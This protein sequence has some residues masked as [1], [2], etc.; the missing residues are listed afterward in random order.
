MS[1]ATFWASKCLLA[2]VH[3]PYDS[4]QRPTGIDDDNSIPIGDF[5][6]TFIKL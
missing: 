6:E 2:Q 4:N 1:K 5:S 3:I